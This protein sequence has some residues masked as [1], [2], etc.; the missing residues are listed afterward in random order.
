M[1]AMMVLA[2]VQ[3]RTSAEG[4]DHPRP[5]EPRW[6]YPPSTMEGQ[7]VA[8]P[9]P[10]LQLAPVFVQT[11]MVHQLETLLAVL[12]PLPLPPVV[13]LLTSRSAPSSSSAAQPQ[14][15]NDMNTWMGMQ[16]LYLC[17][18][19]KKKK[20]KTEMKIS[21]DKAAAYLMDEGQISPKLHA[22]MQAR[23]DQIRLSSSEEE[24]MGPSDADGQR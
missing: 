8:Q 5:L 16:I 11:E 1:E 6:W 15:D 23:I 21:E 2:E 19:K 24:G 14:I 7:A 20:K 3:H 9:H 22:E 10:Q 12:P 18:K 17:P 4:Q 13:R